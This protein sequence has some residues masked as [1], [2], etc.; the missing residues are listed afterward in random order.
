MSF[1]I[2]CYELA[3]MFLED[4]SAPNTEINRRWL[5]QAIQDAIEDELSAMEAEVTE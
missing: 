5:A 3:E 2:K 1:D 4:S